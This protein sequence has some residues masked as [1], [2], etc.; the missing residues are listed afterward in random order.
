MNLISSHY[1]YF[2]FGQYASYILIM[3]T[4][5]DRFEIEY[6]S[7]LPRLAAGCFQASG[8]QVVCKGRLFTKK[9]VNIVKTF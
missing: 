7:C 4:L 1:L 8:E 5:A 2:I 3:I 6:H 9:D